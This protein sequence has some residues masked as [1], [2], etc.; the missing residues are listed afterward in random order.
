MNKIIEISSMLD[1]LYIPKIDS[2]K[3]RKCKWTQINL[4]TEN[5][6]I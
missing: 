6:K 4:P 2:V 5:E 1:E 3:N